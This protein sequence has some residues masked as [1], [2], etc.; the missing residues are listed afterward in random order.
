M[1]YPSKTEKFMNKQHDESKL[2]HVDSTV[3]SKLIANIIAENKNRKTHWKIRYNQV[4]NTPNFVM[5][6]IE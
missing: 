6:K 5:T 3:V 4:K 1:R 2:I